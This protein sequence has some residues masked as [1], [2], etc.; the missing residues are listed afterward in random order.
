MALVLTDRQTAGRTDGRRVHLQ[1]S[2]A[3]Y[4]NAARINHLT[5]AL[6]MSALGWLTVQSNLERS[7]PR[8]LFL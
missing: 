5:N 2:P 7:H 8:D 6:L 1:C 4:R 3:A